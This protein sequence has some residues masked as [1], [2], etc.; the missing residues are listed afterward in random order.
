MRKLFA[1]GRFIRVIT[2]PHESWLNVLPLYFNTFSSNHDFCALMKKVK[3]F[4]DVDLNLFSLHLVSKMFDVFFSYVMVNL[5]AID[6]L[7]TDTSK[8]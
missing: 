1:K 8:G 2:R 5:T 3:R 6:C 7:N 4:D